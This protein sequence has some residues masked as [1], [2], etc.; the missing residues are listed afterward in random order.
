[1]RALGVL[2]VSP[3]LFLGFYYEVK[4]QEFSFVPQ[5]ESP[6]APGRALSWEEQEF[7]RIMRLRAIHA[8]TR[9]PFPPSRVLLPLIFVHRDHPGL[10]IS[11]DFLPEPLFAGLP[12]GNQDH[13]Y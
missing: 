8:G 4:A 13:H 3:L 12:P 9:P 6:G 7:E 11:S 10:G 1:M 5:V 2:I